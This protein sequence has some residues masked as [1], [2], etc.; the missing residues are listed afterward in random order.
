MV[1]LNQL[2]LYPNT[3]HYQTS[4]LSIFSSGT[5]YLTQFSIFQSKGSIFVTFY[6][7]R[8]GPTLLWPSF[9]MAQLY[10][11]PALLW[12]V[13]CP[14]VWASFTMA[15]GPALWPMG[16]SMAPIWASFTMVHDPYGP[17]YGPALLWPSFTMAQLYYGPA[18]LWPSF[19]MAQ[20][21]YGP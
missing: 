4:Q 21:Y 6:F 17:R 9:N 16:P 8:Y 18:L 13:L 20:L 3:V 11:G 19:T 2:I 1:P 5:Q 7:S 14:E 12:P 10:Y 15:R